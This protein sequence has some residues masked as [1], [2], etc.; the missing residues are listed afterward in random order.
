[1]QCGHKERYGAVL[2]ST[3]NST[4]LMAFKECMVLRQPGRTES[5][6]LH[7]AIDSV[8]TWNMINGY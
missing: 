4:V 5:K 6:G 8:L 2:S 3:K 1:M 7:V